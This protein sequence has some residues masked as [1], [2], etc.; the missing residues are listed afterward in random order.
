[1]LFRGIASMHKAQNPEM[2]F[3]ESHRSG[4]GTHMSAPQNYML[5]LRFFVFSNLCGAPFLGSLVVTVGFLSVR[6]LIGVPSA[7]G[8][9]SDPKAK[10][11]F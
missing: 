7:E 6:W 5:P 2:M 11:V 9:Q 10:T 4:Q 1:M 3:I 8:L